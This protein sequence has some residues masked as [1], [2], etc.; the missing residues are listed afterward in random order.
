MVALGPES[1]IFR[2][3]LGSFHLPHE[4]GGGG[5][6]SGSGNDHDDGRSLARSRRL[7]AAEQH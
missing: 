2:P 3:V 5:G 1:L 4:S 6:S 7:V